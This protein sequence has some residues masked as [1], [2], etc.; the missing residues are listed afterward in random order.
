[1]VFNNFCSGKSLPNSISNSALFFVR[2]FNSRLVTFAVFGI[3]KNCFF[4]A[5]SSNFALKGILFV[6]LVTWNWLT[7][8]RTRL[9]LVLWVPIWFLPSTIS[10]EFSSISYKPCLY[11]S[12]ISK[13]MRVPTIGAVISPLWCW[14]LC[15]SWLFPFFS[16][17]LYFNLAVL[18][19]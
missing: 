18:P 17:S 4:S 11:K 3:V 8:R 1:M 2:F 7:S 15:A 14:A 19:L 13:R 6:P 12:V 9:W 5:L 10:R 16:F